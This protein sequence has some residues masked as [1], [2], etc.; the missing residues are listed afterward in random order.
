MSVTNTELLTGP[1]YP[2]GAAVSFAFDF[3]AL[4]KEELV[5]WRGEPGS[6]VSVDPATYSVVIGDQEGGSVV[7]DVAPTALAGPL[8]IEGEPDFRQDSAFGGGEAPFTP[9]AI[10]TEL[11]RGALRAAKLLDGVQRAI[12]VP[13]GERAVDLPGAT[14][15]GGRF[16]AFDPNGNAVAASGTG[17]DAGLRQDLASAAAGG[18][19]VAYR[20]AITNA[21]IVDQ[22]TKSQDLVSRADFGIVGDGI[23]DDTAAITAALIDAQQLGFSLHLPGRYAVS[24]LKFPGAPALQSAYMLVTGE[25]TFVQAVPNTT[26]L[27]IQNSVLQ[28]SA[29]HRFSCTIE[30]HPLSDK[31]DPAN[32]GVDLTGFSTSDIL[33]RLGVAS[34]Y[35]ATTGRFHT[36]IFARSNSPFH[37]G[38][39][40]RYVANAVPAPKFGVR[41]SNDG[42]GVGGNP[43]INAI[44]AWC[45]ALD[46]VAGDRLID[47][48]DSTQAVICGPTLLE[49]CPNAL[50]IKAGSLTSIRDVW[51]ELIGTDM[52]FLPTASTTP[53]NC[54]VERCYFSGGGHVVQINNSL[55]APPVFS[56]CVNDGLVT[57]VDQFGGVLPHMLYTRGYAQPAPPTVAFTMGGGTLS[58]QEN[59]LRLRVDHHGRT[60]S[61]LTFTSPGVVGPAVLRVSP[62]SGYEIEQCVVGVRNSSNE[63]IPAALDDDLAGRDWRWT[64]ENTTD[65]TIN[66]RVMMRAT[67]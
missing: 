67:S 30:P 15:R 45:V 61:Q 5:V 31:S 16:L 29:G 50:G 53:N 33:I 59:S 26:V 41:Y 20:Q 58:P 27:Q 21:P 42:S 3:R 14:S 19:I 18:R 28:Q 1:Y 44:S 32:V 54:T 65:H 37:Y 35:T 46:T 39:H 63:V 34:S 52:E 38:N 66:V 4:T 25:P 49:G 23:T 10:N 11:E 13:R 48:S 60:T 51:F 64:Y 6:W 57:Y 40:I 12:T 24:G 56:E 8:Y 2:N 62:P 7:F 22:Q 17:A 43:N 55:G 47:V 9:K 36:A